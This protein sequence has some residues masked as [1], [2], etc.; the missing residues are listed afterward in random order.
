MFNKVS[1]IIPTYKRSNLLERAIE[2]VLNQTYSNIE[3]VVVDDNI[4]DSQH[5]A[6]TEIKMKKYST[7]YRV[8]YVKNNKSLGGAFARNVGIKNANGKFITFLD[9]DDIYLPHKVGKQLR[10]MLQ[11]DYDLSFTDVRIH[12]SDDVLIDYREHNYITSL[13]N[14]DL[15]KEHLMHH[16]TP[17]STFMFK[18][19]SILKLEGFDDVKMGQEFMLMLK[20]IERGLNIGYMQGADVIQYAHNQERISLGTNKV[21]K[22]IEL[23]NFKKKYFKYLN[24]KEKT[25]I[26][27]RHHAVMMMVG[28]RSGM[29]FLFFIHFFKAI[30]TSPKN[31]LSELL[32][33]KKK[34]KK[35]N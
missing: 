30:I 10:F 6:E 25:Y 31:C 22:E 20:A 33:F 16:L 15:L 18:I 3:V 1:I 7:D 28:K 9:D 13:S 2:S 12:N 26:K 24:K 14:K 17:T 23:Y 19:E 27:F 29:H 35:F 4:P 21:E 5:R 11:N 8:I 32:Y 34:I